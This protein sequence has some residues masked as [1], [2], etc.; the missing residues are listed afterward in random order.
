MNIKINKYLGIAIGIVFFLISFSVG[1]WSKQC[2]TISNT[3]YKTDTLYMKEPI[4]AMPV[5]SIPKNKE[6]H[7]I[8]KIV[9]KDSL[10]NI[11][12]TL[13][14]ESPLFESVDTLRYKGIYVSIID[15]GNCTGIL[16]RQ[17]LFGG[18]LETKVIT[19][20]ITN[21][22]IIPPHFLTL[23]GGANS[24][25]SKEFLLND[26]GPIIELSIKQKYNVGY[27]YFLNSGQHTIHLT[28]KLK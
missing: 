20:T 2:A 7:I 6:I 27:A 4:V 12:D 8:N 11:H 14:M 1:R 28:I 15:T 25:F 9:Y 19:N 5:I 21:N 10:I 26:I 18:E 13:Y 17:S 16:S 22:V 3:V 24:K 23:Y